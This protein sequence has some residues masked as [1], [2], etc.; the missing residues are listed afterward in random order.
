MILTAELHCH[1]RYSD[2]FLTPQQALR[3]AARLGLQVLA[4]TD[5]NTAQGALQCSP[6]SIPSGLLLLPGEEISTEIGHVLAYF[7][8]RTVPPGPFLQVA[9]EVHRQGGLVFIAHPYQIPLANRWRRRPVFR[10][11]EQH[12]S[13]VDG[14]EVE[15]GQNCPAA[16]RLAHQLAWHRR[17]TAI[18][19]SDA[20]FPLEIGN[21]RTQVEC[22]SLSLEALRA[23]FCE[24]NLLPLVRRWNAY[25]LYLLTGILNR[26]SGKYY[27][28]PEMVS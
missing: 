10:L 8:Q 7:I 11:Q 26:W 19:G 13:F 12:W 18:S 23:A 5:H 14:L 17:C 20:H 6:D 4:I 21:A 15:N 24:R 27:A 9:Q 22:S 1:T 2:G 25:P 16:N 3:R 28:D